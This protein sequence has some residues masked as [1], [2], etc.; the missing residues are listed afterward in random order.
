MKANLIRGLAAASLLSCSTVALAAQPIVLD[1][2]QMDHVTAGAHPFIEQLVALLPTIPANANGA[3][4]LDLLSAGTGPLL[5]LLQQALTEPIAFQ[6]LSNG[7]LMA[8]QQLQSGGQ[9]VII[10]QPGSA[11]AA[12]TQAA[13]GATVTTYLLNPGEPINVRQVSSAGTNYMFIQSTGS[14]KA[15]TTQGSTP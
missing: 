9:L 5:Q 13:P 10:K 11:E 14:T 15:V 8:T 2:E 7:D 1:A 6:Q 3:V 4:W 12:A